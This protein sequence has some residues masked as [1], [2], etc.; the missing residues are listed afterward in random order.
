MEKNLLVDMGIWLPE[1]T[2]WDEVAS[3]ITDAIIAVVEGMNGECG[4]SVKFEAFDYDAI[5]AELD[6]LEQEDE[7]LIIQPAS[8]RIIEHPMQESVVY[9]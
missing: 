2:N 5:E 4:G 8:H 3:A 6:L 9:G 1:N 7:P